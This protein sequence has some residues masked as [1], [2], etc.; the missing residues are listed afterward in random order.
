MHAV[1]EE[2]SVHHQALDW[3][4]SRLGGSHD[5]PPSGLPIARES[6]ERPEAPPDGEVPT[7]PEVRSADDLKAAADW[8]RRERHRLEAYTRAQLGRIQQ[9]HQALVGQNY[10]NEQTLILRSQELAR[11]EEVVLAQGR[12]VQQQA[13]ELAQREKAL[14]EQLRAWWEMSQQ[15]AGL[16]EATAAAQQDAACHRS[17]AQAL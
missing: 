16:E 10:L 15:M 7:A 2:R 11:K 12:A 1:G 4:F 9:E 5:V 17:L 6:D 13:Q 14:S 3:L 8:L